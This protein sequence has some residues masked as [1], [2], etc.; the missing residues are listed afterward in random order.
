MKAFTFTIIPTINPD[1]YTYSREHSRLWRKNR[2]DAGGAEKGCWGELAIP[3]SASLSVSVCWIGLD[4]ICS[5]HNFSSKEGTVKQYLRLNGKCRLTPGIDTNTNWGYK[6]RQSRAPVCSD[7]FSGT[8]AFQAYETR[9]MA[10]YLANGTTWTSE[11][12]PESATEGMLVV[13]G[14]PTPAPAP[15]K[16]RVRAF[17]DLHS[18]GQLCESLI[19]DLNF[20]SQSISFPTGQNH[21]GLIQS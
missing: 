3:R 19:Y 20:L 11:P 8:E 5:D 6:W 13:G 16:R 14:E 1:G 10:N 7:T 2:Q 21:V 17:V 9:A 12:D 15:G 4:I 18:Y